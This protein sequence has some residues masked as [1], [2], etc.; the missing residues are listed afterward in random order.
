M[1]VRATVQRRAFS[2]F[3]ATGL[4]LGSSISARAVDQPVQW[5]NQINVTARAGNLQKI[6]GCQGCDDAGAVSRQA[7]RSGDGYVEF[8]VNS[9]NTFWLAGLSR[10]LT[11][12]RFNDIDYALRFNGNGHV[13]V[14]EHGAFQSDD[15]TYRAGDVFGVAIVDGRI[16]YLKNGSIFHE[17]QRSPR[18]PL[19]FAASLGT[20]GATIA[21]ARIETNGRSF[22]RTDNV[23]NRYPSDEF[24]ELDRNGDG[25]VSAREWDGSRQA[26]NQLDLNRDG[27]LSFREF[28]RDDRGVVGTTGRYGTDDR[29][30][31][32]GTLGT[33]GRE[34]IV[35]P[36]RPWTSTGVRVNAG[37]WVAIDAQGSV[38]LSTNPDDMAGPGGSVSGRQALEA[39]M[40]NRSA[41][42]LIGRIGNSAPFFLGE[43]GG[44]SAPSSGELYLGVNDDFL[45]DNSGEY[46]V[47]ITLD[48]R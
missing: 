48:R 5:T 3:I 1:Q 6:D 13:D 12:T 20:V 7:I 4:I 15:T 2:A 18:Y 38:Q 8:R 26:F 11:S 42:A 21:D 27:A 46:H 14:V 33:S 19:V 40:R 47:I 28:S 9:P 23:D 41:G 44:I 16:R 24:S 45:T 36:R 29:S 43:Q 30:G 32:F 39:P 34:F 10:Q 25:V 17:S 22:A 35:D 31:R 37:D